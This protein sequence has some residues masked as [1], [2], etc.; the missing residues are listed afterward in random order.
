MKKQLQV[1][2]GLVVL[3]AVVTSV[4]AGGVKYK[5]EDGDY[6]KLGGRIQLQ[7]HQMDVDGGGS[8]DDLLFRR[9]RPYIEGSVNENWKGKWQFD[10]GKGK[11]EVKDAYAAY[12]GIEGVQIAF[13]NANFPFSREF[14]TSS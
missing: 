9:L 7:Y 4:H 5:N 13:G 3:G 6:V 1:I 10:L 8:T 2:T 11:V 12:T 14:L